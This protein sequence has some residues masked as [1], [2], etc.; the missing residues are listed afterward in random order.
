MRVLAGL[1]LLGI[2]QV[3]PGPWPLSL[4]LV[5]VAA[6]AGGWAVATLRR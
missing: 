1:G 2:Q 6:V 5:A 3:A 4:L